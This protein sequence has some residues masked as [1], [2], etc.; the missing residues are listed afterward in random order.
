[1][2]DRFLAFLAHTTP[3]HHYD[4]PLSEVIQGQDPL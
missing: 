3:V 1:M 2:I 4:V